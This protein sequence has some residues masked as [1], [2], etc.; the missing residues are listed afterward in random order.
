MGIV[1]YAFAAPDQNSFTFKWVDCV[2]P[3][4]AS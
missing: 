3:L 2:G 4:S 1:G